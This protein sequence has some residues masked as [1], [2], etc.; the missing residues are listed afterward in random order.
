[1]PAASVRAAAGAVSFLTRVPVGRVVDVQAADV[2]R[3]AVL[4]PLV[5]A[6]VGALAGLT[7]AGLEHQLPAFVAASV[8]VAVA[9]VLTGAMH[10][11]AL[12]DTADALGA[13]GRD[14]ALAIMRDSRIGSFGAVALVLDLLVKVGCVAA[15]LAGGHV[16][17]GLVAAGA[18]SRAVSPSL[19]A[20]LPYPRAAG[21]P[22]SVLSGRTSWPAAAV[23]AAIGAALALAVWRDG[24]HWLVAA[25]VAVAVAA[26]LLYRR[27]LGGATGD[28]LG[29]ATELTETCV[30]LVAVVSL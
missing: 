7:A 10:L 23:A 1:M 17:A 29:A 27:W 24:G 14:E 13:T 19:A 25:A 2:A 6:G 18:L 15:L 4:F 28:C 8:A 12:A 21:G 11:D 30:L 3:A 9:A 26:G 22:G 20:V 16:I 5:G